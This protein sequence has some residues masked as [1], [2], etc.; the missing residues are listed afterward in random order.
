MRIDDRAG[1]GAGVGAGDKLGS[2][3]VILAATASARASEAAVAR[4]FAVPVQRLRAAS[5]GTADI[6]LARQ[7]AIYLVR[8][9]SEYRFADVGRA[10][11]RDRTTAAHACWVVEDRRDDGEFDRVLTALEGGLAAW[12]L[13]FGAAR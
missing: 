4:A 9:G 2:A 5:R 10:F 13:C 1:A 11:G 12:S 3:A 6:A 7:V 8:V